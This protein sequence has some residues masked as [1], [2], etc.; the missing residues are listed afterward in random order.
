MTADWPDMDS[1]GVT[2]TDE[3]VR[4]LEDRIGTT[5]PDEYRAFLLDVNGG[6]PGARHRVLTLVNEQ[7]VL[8]DLHSLSSSGAPFDI[9][10]R[11]ERLRVQVPYPLIPIGSAG[12][13]SHTG[14]ICLCVEG[15]ERGTIWYSVLGGAPRAHNFQHWSQRPD[16]QLL[17]ENFGAFVASLGPLGIARYAN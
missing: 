8:R 14:A 2:V 10:T 12:G 15:P 5:L 3:D 13:A 4:A 11:M 7:V 17:A 6:K 16:V 9:V 1:T